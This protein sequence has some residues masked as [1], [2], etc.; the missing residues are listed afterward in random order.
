MQIIPAL[1]TLNTNDL[2]K[3]IQNLSLFFKRFQIDIADGKFVP[4]STVQIESLL[5]DCEHW[6]DAIKKE[7]VFDFHLMVEDYEK[8]IEKIKLIQDKLTVD[9]VFIHVSRIMASHNSYEDQPFHV[10]MVLNPEDSV[11]TFQRNIE[12][13]Q[14][15]V[16]TNDIDAVQIMTVHPGFQGQPFLPEQLEK[17]NELRIN[18]FT[19]NIFIDGGINDQSL[20]LIKQLEYK[21][22]FLCIGSYL[23]HA[24]NITD[25]LKTVTSLD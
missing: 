15:N 14:R 23:T 11:E 1:L 10:G 22:D 12:A 9:T 5:Q 25:Q 17:I 21:P 19:K 7:C 20:P 6:D 2:Y 16:S 18:G 24:E 8:E 13:L 3:Q 4:N